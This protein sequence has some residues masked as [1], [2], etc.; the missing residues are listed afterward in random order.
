MKNLVQSSPSNHFFSKKNSFSLSEINYMSRST[1]PKQWFFSQIDYFIQII[2]QSLSNW[3]RDFI[4][5]L[6]KSYFSS[7]F[8]TQDYF[9]KKFWAGLFN[10]KI[11]ILI[12]EVLKEKLS[13]KKFA[14]SLINLQSLIGKYSLSPQVYEEGLEQL[15]NLMIYSMKTN[16]IKSKWRTSLKEQPDFLKE[17]LF[18]DVLYDIID[19][20]EEA[21][22]QKILKKSL[23]YYEKLLSTENYL[24]FICQLRNYHVNENTYFHRKP[25]FNRALQTA[26][27]NTLKIPS[28]L[29]EKILVS[30]LPLNLIK[31]FFGIIKYII[32]HPAKAITL[33]LTAQIFNISGLMITSKN[34]TVVNAKNAL[35]MLSIDEVFMLQHKAI[36]SSAFLLDKYYFN[37][38]DEEKLIF[39]QSADVFLFTDNI[40][41]LTIAEKLIYWF[42]LIKNKHT[43]GIV[44]LISHKLNSKII[45][46]EQEKNEKRFTNKE[47]VNK[48]KI[49]NQHD[50]QLTRIEN[51]LKKLQK[52]L[53]NDIEILNKN[54]TEI[55]ITI[56]QQN[57]TQMEREKEN[58]KNFL[59]FSDKLIELQTNLMH[60]KEALNKNITEIAI[61]I[62]QQNHTQ[63][64]REKENN[65]KFLQ[66][67]DNL[68]ELQTNLMHHKEALNKNITEIAITIQQQNHTK[69]EREK[70]NN[71]K[72]LQFSDNFIE[73]QTNLMHDKE[74]LN[75]NITEMRITIQQQMHTQIER[76]KKNNKKIL[77]VDNKIIALQ[78]T[79][80]KITAIFSGEIVEIMGLIEDK[81]KEKIKSEDQIKEEFSSFDNKLAEVKNNFTNNVDRLNKNIT[82]VYEIIQRNEQEKLQEKKYKL[83][84]TSCDIVLKCQ[85]QI[86]SFENKF[87]EIQ[88]NLNNPSN[89]FKNNITSITPNVLSRERDGREQNLVK[90]N[91]VIEECILAIKIG[92]INKAKIKLIRISRFYKANWYDKNLQAV[93]R[94]IIRLSYDSSI[95]NFKHVDKFIREGLFSLEQAAISYEVLVDEMIKSNHS[96]TPELVKLGYR[97]K[98]NMGMSNYPFIHKEYLNKFELLKF[99]LPITIKNILWDTVYIK[100]FNYNEYLN[101]LND[102]YPETE[103]IFTEIR[104][105]N[106]AQEPC[107]KFST[108]DQGESFFIRY[109]EDENRYLHATPYN[110]SDK[111][112]V[113]MHMDNKVGS[114]WKV[115]PN[116]SKLFKLQNVYYRENLSAAEDFCR[117]D[118]KRR[119]VFLSDKDEVSDVWEIGACE[120]DKL[121]GSEPIS[122]RK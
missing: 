1:G 5:D 11:E 82:E 78:E 121:I 95:D 31:I 21:E 38:T 109:V 7:T 111:R 29:S 114:S 99:N 60:H 98:E 10:E 56:Q 115:A 32:R 116:N 41:N 30:N 37:L 110:V 59:Q 113:S 23:S 36:E 83:E 85:E 51:G 47:I 122:Y 91:S 19:S 103:R 100:N 3:F 107:W 81:N 90:K 43:L 46:L 68:I 94:K 12:E 86:E 118:L 70:E 89:F 87:K 101:V 33:G 71:K 42:S 34:L 64:E 28:Y 55:A 74:S 2:E 16:Q 27:N 52:I 22:K 72:F 77:Q 69:V 9:D 50:E 66:F 61:T 102:T 108:N 57:H 40:K 117:Y 106:V 67:S 15:K 112:H 105:T 6:P 76:E 45:K 75:K 17:C 20:V 120:S 25:V 92:N 14:I 44:D 35:S 97:I 39:K 84:N 80:N 48:F 13:E 24:A 73:L 96:Y 104:S 119:R 18:G 93:L 53:T 26:Q 8:I 88:A 63:V 79:F 62:Q 49:I 65:K 58:N 4:S 54:I